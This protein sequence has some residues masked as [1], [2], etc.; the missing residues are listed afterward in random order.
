MAKQIV[1]PGQED[2][3]QGEQ[4]TFAQGPG[5]S[6]ITLEESQRQQAYR[7]AHPELYAY[8]PIDSG[9]GFGLGKFIGVVLAVASLAVPGLGE[10]VGAAILEAVGI[11]GATVA[12]EAGVGAAALSAGSAAAQGGSV[13]DVLKSAATAGFASGINVGMGGGVSG[14][15]TGSLV[16][17]AIQGGSVDQVL[18]N[19]VAAGAG[20]G[21][22][23]V[24]GPAAGTITRDLIKTGDV[25]DQT[26]IKAATAEIGSW[27]KSNDR[28][29][30]I[31]E[32]K[33]FTSDV[34]EEAVPT[35]ILLEPK[36]E[37]P[38]N[39]SVTVSDTPVK[40]GYTDYYPM[41]NGGAAYTDDQGVVRYISASEFEADK[42]SYGVA[43]PTVAAE[44]T[45][46][47]TE[48]L[49]PQTISATAPAVSPTVTDVDVIK[50]IQAQQQ[51]VPETIV[52][53][54]PPTV[55]EPPPAPTP[56]TTPELEKVTVSAPSEPNVAPVVTD[57]D[58]IKQVSQQQPSVVTPQQLQQVII[59]G[60]GANVANVL[61]VE[62]TV[63]G[64]T[65]S[66][67]VTT[68]LDPVT[69]TGKKE[70][71]VS[72][73]IT[74]LPPVTV[75][76]QREPTVEFPQVTVTGQKEPVYE[77]PQ[78]TVTGQKEPTYELPQ[79]TV[80]GQRE[81]T[82]ELPPV[83]VTRQRDPTV[84]FPQVTVTGQR[85]PTYEFDPV[86]ITGKRDPIYELDPVTVTGK[87]EEFVA[88]VVTD[89]DVMQQIAAQQ[90]ATLP[91]VTV[92][93]QTEPA[94]ELP[95]VTV[96]GKKEEPVAPVAT[97]IVEPRP[98]TTRGLPAPTAELPPVTVT[99]KQ[100]EVAP[101]VTEL[102]PVT[103]TGRQEPPVELPPVTVTGQRDPIYE[104]PP[105]TVTGKRE[106]EIS[107]V[108]TQL[109]PVTITGKRDP[110]YELD[111]V[112]ITAKSN[113]P[114]ETPVPPK[115]K[116]EEPEKPKQEPKKLYPTVTSVPPPKKPGRQPI[117]TGVSPARLLADA[118]AAYR[119]AGAIEG[120]ESGKE[121]QNVWNEK[122][123]RLKDALGL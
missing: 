24:L 43:E 34:S 91:P 65:P 8:V 101:T 71:Q 20:A 26:L 99:G 3:L 111:P 115:K 32:G 46:V 110:V 79:V 45:T 104:L 109:D 39:G 74:E 121:R 25:S 13:E 122:S 84:E 35:S 16:G 64:T 62:T 63:P 90:Q 73:A 92:T 66:T 59:Q 10:I 2:L 37:T 56:A 69:I 55:T 67:G 38:S 53:I 6:S 23:G 40:V 113:E 116:E 7:E 120:E 100:E 27:N 15:A 72:P 77:L 30:P 54:F 112:T 96:T 106:E 82:Y 103:V 81:P 94:V 31:V 50:Q 52:P 42:S 49:P 14:A 4:Q 88:P 95:P 9:G 36:A 118:L 108:V 21:V 119:P 87:R 41:S 44:P 48:T 97:D 98:D 57:L 58:L 123:L 114:V 78:V 117:I 29:A 86:T 19:A 61:P 89:L 22:Q 85:D 83:T 12:V 80:T 33:P 28:Q 70:E 18:L 68:A 1:A 5:L 107:P 11:T 105:V 47:A 17:S 51:A 60:Q 93:G 76:G 75:T 102:P